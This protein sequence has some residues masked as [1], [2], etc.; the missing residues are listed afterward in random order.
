MPA[1][2][3]V[4]ERPAAIRVDLGAIFVSME[5]S[6]PKWLSHP[7]RRAAG[8]RCRSTWSPAAIWRGCWICLRR[9]R[10]R[11]RRERAAAIGLSSSRRRV[12][13]GSGSTAPWR[14]K[15]SKA[16]W[17]TRPRSRLRGGRSEPR[18]TASMARRWCGRSWP[19]SAASRGSAR[20]SGRPVQ[21]RKI[22]GGWCA[23]ARR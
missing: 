17:S 5:L 15:G 11:R 1:A 7:C 22:A 14:R 20:W 12:S 9:C 4:S 6:R 19:T 16:M 10:Q 18:R 2:T 21:K 3:S 23:N 13:M 8:R